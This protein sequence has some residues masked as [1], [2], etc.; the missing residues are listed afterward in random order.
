MVF[1]D[2]ML[3]C[4]DR[5]DPNIAV[6]K[7]EALYRLLGYESSGAQECEHCGRTFYP[8]EVADTMKAMYGSNTM[9]WDED[10]IVLTYGLCPH[11]WP[12]PY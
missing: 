3:D 8:R 1:A 2:R 12:E 7:T 5:R 6:R 4:T 9:W 10:Y 11:C